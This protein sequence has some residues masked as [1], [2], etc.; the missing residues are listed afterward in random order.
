MSAHDYLYESIVKPNA[1]IVPGFQAGLMPQNFAH[2]RPAH[3]ELG[4]HVAFDKP[5]SRAKIPVHD[6]LANLVERKLSQRLD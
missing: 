5:V 3:A 2:D 4:T 6:G 1:F